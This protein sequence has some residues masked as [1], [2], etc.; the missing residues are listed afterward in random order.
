MKKY[1][2]MCVVACTATISQ[3]HAAVAID[4]WKLDN[5]ARVYFVA[6]HAL[7]I[8]DVS[9]QFD[10]G[11]RRD[12]ENKAGL[13]AMTNT[14]LNRGV[15]A[16]GSLPALTESQVLDGFADIVASYGA[17]AGSDQGGVGVRVLSDKA[18]RTAAINLL[19]RVLANPGFPE[20]ALA[21]DKARMISAL[22]DAQTKPAVIADQAFGKAMYG[23]HPYGFDASPETIA[24]L[25]R[26]DIVTFHRQHYVANTAVITMVGDLSKDEAHQIATQL[27]A[28]LP[29]GAALPAMPPVPAPVA[30]DKR[31]AHPAS[32]SHIMIGLPALVRGDEDFFTL[33]VG[34]YILGGGGFV[35]RLMHEVR[36]KRGLTYGVSSSFSGMA[37]EGPFEIGLQTKKEKTDEALKV[38]LDTLNTFLKSGPTASELKAAKDNLIGGF[39]L[40][41]DSNRKILSLVAMIA[42]YD[43]PLDYLDTWTDKVKRVTAAQVQAAFLRKVKADKLTVVV[44]GQAD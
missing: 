30:S 3:V 12:T 16:Q 8:V 15:D 39:A 26:E 31:I 22:K 29:Q 36:E 43:L 1:L 11:A 6:S 10:A 41:L 9:V 34:N 27:T 33:L 37:Q 13:A 17:S 21:R 5:G 38:T 18:D 14:L 19:S 40:N 4:T 2:L 25:S 32:Q 20:E 24:Q 23:S 7:P 28:H 35:S 42:Y 44:V